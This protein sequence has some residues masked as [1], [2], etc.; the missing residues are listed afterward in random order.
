MWQ[1]EDLK[2]GTQFLVSFNGKQVASI[3]HA[4]SKM[5]WHAGIT[6][7]LNPYLLR[8]TFGTQLIAAGV[9]IGT[10]AKL[11]GHSSPSMLLR[12]YQ[13]VMDV[14][15]KRAIDALPTFI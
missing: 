13:Y 8:H 7:D 3:K 12:H 10:V 4:W 15:K 2:A 11:M 6:R 1:D 9:D 5:L 14:Q